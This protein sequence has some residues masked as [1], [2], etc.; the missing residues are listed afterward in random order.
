MSRPRT[1]RAERILAMVIAAAGLAGLVA[2]RHLDFINPRG[3]FL[4]DVPGDFVWGRQLAFNPLGA[5]LMLAVGLLALGAV[6]TRRS[7]LVLVA[8]ALAIAL[9]VGTAV[10]LARRD[11]TRG[12]RAGN[13]ALRLALGLGLGAIELSVREEPETA[14][15]R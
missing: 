15:R 9:A 5:L 2:S 13:A 6:Q 14:R 7:S 4:I 3:T 10:D 12:S 1:Q 11:P 8:A